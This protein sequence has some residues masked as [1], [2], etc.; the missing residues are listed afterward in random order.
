MSN[1]IEPIRIRKPSVAAS[2]CAV[3]ITIFILGACFGM[4]SAK[5]PLWQPVKGHIMT[6]WAKDVSATNVLP[7]YPRPM[8]KRENWKNLNGLWEFAM[9]PK[10][11]ASRPEKFDDHILV[12]FSVE[13]ALS[14]IKKKVVETD[15][16]WYR[17]NFDVP[18]EW[19]GRRLLLH[20]GAVDWETTVWINDKE[21][22][23]H[24]GGYDPFSIDI[25][26]MLNSA[27]PQEVVLNVWDPTDRAGQAR[28]KQQIVPEGFMY[29]PSSGIWQTV[30]LEPV[31]S[32][33]I[34]SIRV[35]PDI[36]ENCVW[37]TVDAANT[38]D[39]YTIEAKTLLPGTGEKAGTIPVV[40]ES[41]AGQCLR[42]SLR[43]EPKTR[44]WS[45]DSPFLYDLQV[46]LKDRTGIY[47]T[48][49]NFKV[50]DEVVPR[51][52]ELWA[53]G[54][55]IGTV[56]KLLPSDV[57][58]DCWVNGKS[59]TTIYSPEEI[60]HVCQKGQMLFSFAKN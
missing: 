31:P 55:N 48:K 56:R 45:P 41:R 32:S 21:A 28:G 40:A 11:N 53:Q 6:C 3:L 1:C 49:E 39:A 43:K 23:H 29:T 10:S 46:T 30:W 18:K 54:N 15:R 7:E 12:P 9:R 16:L 4:V 13:S 44:L 35:E 38:N 47:L 26:D 57:I 34:R 2:W 25:T 42:I 50:G 51:D 5:E 22:T 37:V 27:G 58:V 60:K 20:F 8:M 14:G 36:D 24:R 59:I 17:R 33:H 19:T 52:P